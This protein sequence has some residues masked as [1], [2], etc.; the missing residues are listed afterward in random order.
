M[1]KI[2]LYP[3]R[4]EAIKDLSFEEKWKL[5]DCFFYYNGT[6]EIN[7]E[8]ALKAVFNI[9]KNRLD[10]DK[11]EYNKKCKKNK[12]IA[13]DRE[14]KKK[15]ERARTC[16][17]VHHEAPQPTNSNSNTNSN[18]INNNIINKEDINILSKDNTETKVSESKEISPPIE[19]KPITVSINNLIGTIKQNASA[20]GVAYSSDKDREFAK[21]ILTAKAYWEFCESI[22]MWREEFA[23]S[24]M[25]ESVKNSYWK[26]ACAWPKKIY[27]EYP[28]VYNLYQKNI[29]KNTIPFIPTI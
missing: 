3:E 16:T 18:N 8:W 28:E 7:I 24:V 1:Y 19:L 29:H 22:G 4:W 17:N 5:L 26:W 12:D 9:F 13:L 11:E 25:K 27:Q 2:W 6:W 21:H 10:N 15:H 20:L 14:E 23:I